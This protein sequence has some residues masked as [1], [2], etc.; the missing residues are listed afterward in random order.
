MENGVKFDRIMSMRN[1]YRILRYFRSFPYKY[2]ELPSRP[3]FPSLIIGEIEF[4]YYLYEKTNYLKDWRI[5]I[6][7]KLRRLGMEVKISG[8]LVHKRNNNINLA[9]EGCREKGYLELKDVNGNLKITSKG[10]RFSGIWGVGF[11]SQCLDEYSFN[12]LILGGIIGGI[13]VGA[14]IVLILQKFGIL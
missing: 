6:K 3:N 13:P 4:I 8:D 7:E 1:M 11:Y 9:I 12:K 10:Q 2:K 14:I 5:I